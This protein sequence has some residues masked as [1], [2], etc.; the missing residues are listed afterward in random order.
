MTD[1]SG[2]LRRTA[3]IAIDYRT[4]LATRPVGPPVDLAAL[5]A[6]LGGPLP[7]GPTD[8]LQVVEDLAAAADP[9]L[10]ASA[11]PR[12][13]GFVIG[14]GLPAALGGRLADERLG[15]ERRACTSL[16]PGRGRRGGGRPAGWLLD[17]LGLPAGDE[18]R[19]RRPVRRWPTSPRSPPRRHAVLA[20]DRLGR[21][22]AT[23]SQGAPLGH[24][25]RRRGEPRHRA[26]RRSRCSASGG[27]RPRPH[28]RG[29]RSGPDAP[30]CAARRTGRRSTAR[31]SSAPRPAT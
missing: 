11:G 27:R 9:G 17:L 21:R 26:T 20:A 12:Y 10:V 28:G 5:R 30:R 22:A 2:L 6:A 8:P 18:R 16:S 15:P 13:F 19:F 29:R 3:E 14:G 24:G 1:E 4:S 31:S 23:G 25:H 7:D